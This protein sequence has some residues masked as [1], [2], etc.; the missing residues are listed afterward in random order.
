MLT[1]N[2][3]IR[4]KHLFLSDLSFLA[5]KHATTW[6]W[7]KRESY[8]TCGGQC[9]RKKDCEGVELYSQTHSKTGWMFKSH[10]LNSWSSMVWQAESHNP[11]AGCR[12]TLHGQNRQV[13]WKLLFFL[14]SL[15]TMNTIS[16]THSGKKK[17]FDK[18]HN[19]LL[20]RTS[21][22]LFL[23]VDHAKFKKIGLNE[24]GDAS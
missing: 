8:Q 14:V 16:P 10:K 9:F 21:F 11:T 4:K 19:L 6:T 20:H 15:F 1:T 12:G 17:K 24:K 3:L 23:H 2:R 22:A 13:Y 18:P 7:G 5:V